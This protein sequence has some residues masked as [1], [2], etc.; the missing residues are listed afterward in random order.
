MP[1]VVIIAGLLKEESMTERQPEISKEMREALES[2]PPTPLPTPEPGSG[3]E[4][5]IFYN[6]MVDSVRSWGYTLLLLGALHVI[7]AGTLSAPWGIL[8]LLVGVASFYFKDAAMFLVYAATI[9]W[10]AIYNLSSGSPLWIGFALLQCYWAF[11]QFRDFLRFRRVQEAYVA[12]LI[13]HPTEG[14][15]PPLRAARV[16][17]WAAFVLGV[18]AVIGFAAGFVWLVVTR[19]AQENHPVF[20]ILELLTWLSCGWSGYGIGGISVAL[21]ASTSGCDRHVELQSGDDC[22]AGVDPI[23]S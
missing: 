14:S 2:Q 22:L 11:G 5:G 23:V 21:Q 6:R 9:A 13:A 18:L 15:V 19:Q 10:A 20:T 1:C 8:L 7:A 3:S 16:F 4:A 12:Y 17:P